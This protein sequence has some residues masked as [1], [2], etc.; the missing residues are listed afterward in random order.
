MLDPS[1][2][3]LE[4]Q[5]MTNDSL[6]NDYYKRAKSRLKILY[7]LLED[8][9][10]ADVIRESQEL[11]E[12]LLKAWLRKIGVE[13]PKW[14]DVAPILKIHENHLPE[15][16]K[17]EL[18]LI[19]EFSKYLRK[20]RENSFYGDEDLIPLE[21]FSAEDANQCLAKTEWLLNLFKD[22]FE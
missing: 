2:N 11:V 12:L 18:P 5:V 8:N 13:P 15:N 3:L 6:S 4:I 10:H 7:V 20:E 21:S 19:L 16:I 1:N 14:H 9:N 22:V 17:Q